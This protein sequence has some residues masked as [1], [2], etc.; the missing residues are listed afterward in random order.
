MTIPKIKVVEALKDLLNEP[1]EVVSRE[2]V[3][4][5]LRPFSAKDF[6]QEIYQKSTYIH[7]LDQVIKQSRQNPPAS[8]SSV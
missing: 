1:G 6:T 7:V 8:E 3:V 5:A 4:S 2:V